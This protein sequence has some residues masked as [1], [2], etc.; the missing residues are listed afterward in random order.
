MSRLPLRQH[1]NAAASRLANARFASS[2]AVRGLHGS[3]AVA[4]CPA[5]HCNNGF[6]VQTEDDSLWAN[7]EPVWKPWQSAE[8]PGYAPLQL[9]E[10]LVGQYA[11][12]KVIR[13]LNWGVESS[14]WL[15]ER[16]ASEHKALKP[17]KLLA[18]KVL[19]AHATELEIG[20]STCQ[21]PLL[22]EILKHSTPPSKPDEPVNKEKF[23]I[24]G[25]EFT[26]TMFDWG[27]H[28]TRIGVHVFTIL[29]PMS[30]TLRKVQRAFRTMD[31]NRD[32][33]LVRRVVKQMLFALSC[34]HQLGYIHGDVKADNIC[35]PLFAEFIP[36]LKGYLETAPAESL[37]PRVFPDYSPDPVTCV[38]S[39]PY[40]PIGDDHHVDKIYIN[41]VDFS[42]A[43]HASSYSTTQRA[44]PR[45]L[46]A[47]EVILGHRWG[48]PIDIWALGCLAAELLLHRPLFDPGDNEDDAT[49][50]EHLAQM[51]EVLGP[52]SQGA[53]AKCPL[54]NT[55]FNTNGSLN[56]AD[57]GR[58]VHVPSLRHSLAEVGL[59]GSTL[60]E[61]DALLHRMLALD[62]DS[63]PIASELLNDPFVK[64]LNLETNT[65]L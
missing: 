45:M 49:D 63:R 2:S 29:A 18:A 57:G 9:G 43:I 46:R 34:V 30:T 56:S 64:G 7:E 44:M 8:S 1:L 11:Q 50:S 17:G 39:Q 36:D 58:R 6:R 40:P 61:V 47:P 33:M 12:Y 48:Q 27:A 52:F 13:K 38:K 16:V 41:L 26:I 10:G 4:G 19:T 25:S 23:Y 42:S 35:V 54:T 3:G 15:V 59:A 32:V 14:I 28:R 24:P 22:N 55:F 60:D 20:K 62:P 5:K 31:P 65:L 53:L 51:V 21:I 37:P